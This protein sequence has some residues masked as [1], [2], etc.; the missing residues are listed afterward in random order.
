MSSGDLGA[1]ARR[2]R[3]GPRRDDV[4]C[5]VKI[6]RSEQKGRIIL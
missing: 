2:F 1:K 4:N 6:K 3:L 5:E